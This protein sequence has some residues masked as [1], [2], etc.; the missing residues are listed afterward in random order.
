MKKAPNGSGTQPIL[1]KDGRWQAKYTA[2]IDKG[3]GKPI[4]VNVYGKTQ[5]ECAKKLREA[6]AQ[7]DN[8]THT[9]PCKMKLKAWI[10]IWLAEYLNDRKESTR[11]GYYWNCKTHILPALG[12]TRL[13]AIKPHDVQI[14]VN[15]LTAS[16][17]SPYTVKNIYATLSGCLEESHRLRYIPSNPCDGTK[18]PP[19]EKNEIKPLDRSETILFEKAIKGTKFESILF[20]LLNTGMRFGEANGLR[21]SCI[22][23]ENKTITVSGQVTM[24]RGN[25]NPSFYDI[26]KNKKSRTFP[27][28]N[29]VITELKKVQL[30]QKEMKLKAG[31]Y[32]NSNIK[33]K[34]GKEISDLVFTAENGNAIC[35]ASVYK[36]FKRII[37]SIGLS[38]YRIHDLRHTFATNSLRLGIDILTLSKIFLGHSDVSITL[39]LYT[40]STNEMQII[41]QQKLDDYRKLMNNA[42]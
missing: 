20:I 11:K 31:E 2:G 39:N 34:K 28:C 26:P 14:F 5:Q 38:G 9:E 42:V 12:N 24:R 17:L 10:E 16:G 1:R 18:L 13:D 25:T 7:L 33:D 36:Q 30:H 3:T 22:D 32:W 15:K 21:W 37:E 19:I 35:Y 40:H 27:V 41:A 29:D 4:R 23:F 8:G 6:T